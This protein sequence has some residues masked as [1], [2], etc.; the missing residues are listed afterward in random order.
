M[1]EGC[2]WKGIK[3]VILEVEEFREGEGRVYEYMECKWKQGRGN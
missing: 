2:I 1:S 3:R